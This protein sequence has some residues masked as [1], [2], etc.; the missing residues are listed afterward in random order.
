VRFVSYGARK[1]I[2]E[3]KP[4]VE[5]PKPPVDICPFCGPASSINPRSHE[6]DLSQLRSDHAS[7]GRMSWTDDRVEL[8]TKLWGDGLSAS[9]IGAELGGIS[10]NSVISKV[11]RLGLPPRRER[12]STQAKN[13]RRIKTAAKQAMDRFFGTKSL[14]PPQPQ[15]IIENTIPIGQR[16]SILELTEGKC[17]WPIGDP[18]SSD[19]FFCGGKTIEGLPYCGY[20]SRIAYQ[21]AADRRRTRRVA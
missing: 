11:H 15:E 1:V 3:L 12:P 6:C 16:C 20:H 7:G 4:P 10:R 5:P 8:L 21:P 19:F 13:N 18:S 14:P 9:Q 17:H 2:E